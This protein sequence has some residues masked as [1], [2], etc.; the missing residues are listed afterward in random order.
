MDKFEL[1]IFG[2]K[3][4]S[5]ARSIHSI[6]HNFQAT[7]LTLAR[8][9]KEM[10][11]QELANRV[12]L[13]TSAISQIES[14]KTNPD[15]RNVSQIA[16]A[17]G[18]SPEFFARRM[19]SPI[20]PLD[21]CHFRSLRSASQK[22]RKRLLA[23]GTLL[24]DILSFCEEYI[25]F[26]EDRVSPFVRQTNSLQDIELLAAEMRRNW[27]LGLG[28]ISEIIKL[29]EASGIMVTMMP[30]S[31]REVNAFST[32]IKGKPFIF[33][34]NK[35]NASDI[36]FDAGHELYHLLAHADAIPG[37]KALEKEADFFSGC[38]LLP[39]DSYYRESPKRLNWKHF[40]ELKVRWG[41]SYRCLIVRSYQLGCLS[42]YQYHRAF[43]ELNQMEY[44]KSNEP[45]E[46]V[47]EYPFL[48]TR[49][50][51]MVQE[52]IS[53]EDIANGLGLTTSLFNGLVSPY[54]NEAN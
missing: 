27:G 21:S 52:D 34:A 32:W 43:V 10:T 48:L 46:P 9:L 7:R 42:E 47:M 16:L 39:R 37:D 26:P 4:E 5:N 15:F 13:S 8:D 31:C 36:R 29:L 3:Q 49:L 11:K 20:L 1:K 40:E 14:G 28:P 24:Y 2:G 54:G 45:N 30:N 25:E 53:L 6:A 22:Q 35:G 41:V 18:V 33:L 17:L 38:F 23:I 19:S 50:L 44:T 12:G 51:E